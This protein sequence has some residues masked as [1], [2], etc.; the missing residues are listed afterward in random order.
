M[1]VKSKNKYKVGPYNLAGRL[2]VRK[3]YKIASIHWSIREILKFAW[4]W[5]SETSVSCTQNTHF[6]N[7]ALSSKRLVYARR[8]FSKSSVVSSTRGATFFEK[9][10]S[11]L[12]KT[13]TLGGNAEPRPPK[14][15]PAEPTRARKKSCLVYAKRMF[16]ESS[17]NTSP[18][19]YAKRTLPNASVLSS[20]RD[21]IFLA[22]CR[23]VYAKHPLWEANTK[24]SPA[25]PSR[26]QL[27]R[28]DLRRAEIQTQNK[29]AS[30]LREML[31]FS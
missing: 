26:A 13:T 29:V 19:V 16:T 8:T 10:Q 17:L 27:S 9:L 1:R 31:F 5:H 12:R 7:I 3:I 14:P 21:A 24:P 4:R 30:R 18:L 20:T 23:L 15:S 22:N 11:R 2:R 25:R 28:A 6:Q